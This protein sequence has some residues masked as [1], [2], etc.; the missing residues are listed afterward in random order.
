MSQ[1]PR[2]ATGGELTL[3]RTP[4]QWSKVFAAILVPQVI[5]RAR[6][7]QTFST[8][9]RVLEVTYDTPSGTLG[10]VRADMTVLV[11]S[12]LDA[13]DKGICRLRSID[14]TKFYI[15]KTSDIAWA[16][17]LFLTVINDFG[18]WAREITM[19][20]VTAFMDSGIAYTNQH[21]NFDPVVIMGDHRVLKKTGASIST[22]FDWTGS[23]MPDGSAVSSYSTSAPTSSSSSGMTTSAPT[24]HFNAVGWHPIYLTVTGANGKSFFGMRWVY[25]YDKNNLP[26][27]AQIGDNGVDVDSGGWQ[28]S[29]TLS[30]NVDL[31]LVR[32]RALVLVFAEDHYGNTVQSIGPITNCENR[33]LTGW[34][35]AESINWNPEQGQVEFTCYGA[36]HWMKII[37][38]YPS[39][40]EHTTKT[41][42]AWTEI[43]NLNVRLGLFHFLH[44]RT[45]ATRVMDVYLPDD[46]RI[47]AECSSL[48]G[49]LW[50][51]ITE[52]AWDKTF[53][54]AGVDRFNRLWIK[55][56]PQLTPTASRTW[57]TVMDITEDD[58]AGDVSFERAIVNE[59]SVVDMSGGSINSAGKITPYFALSPGRAFPHY[60]SPDIVTGHLFS[61][62]AECLTICGLYWTWRNNQFKDIPIQFSSNMRLIDC[63]PN[64]KCTITIASGDTPRGIAYSGG[65]IPTSVKFVHNADTG[66]LYTEAHFEAE[67]FEGLAVVGDFIGSDDVS[68]PPLAPLPPLPPLDYPIIPGVIEPSEE[69]GPP[70]VLLHGTPGLIYTENFNDDASDIGWLVMNPGLTQAQYQQISWIGLDASGGIYVARR[71]SSVNAFIAY[72][73]QIGATFTIIEDMASIDAKY[74]GAVFRGV[75]AIGVDPLTG[76]LAYVLTG[77]LPLGVMQSHIY[78]GSGTSFTQG[79]DLSGRVHVTSGGSLSFGGGAWRLTTNANTVAPRFIAISADG[80]T[81]LSQTILPGQVQIEAAEQ[82]APVSTTDTILMRIQHSLIRVTQNGAVAGDFTNY[83]S[84]GEMPN[85]APWDNKTAC[86]PSGTLIMACWNTSGRKGKSADGGSSFT[87]MP[88]LPPGADYAYA[89]A[90]GAGVASRWI[91]GLGTTLRYSDDFGGAWGDKSANLLNTVSFTPGIDIIKVVEY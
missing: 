74:P 80:S 12:T 8:T 78:V 34:I 15:G 76:T 62:Q 10:N 63:F 56:H 58:W 22:V 3:F 64:Q 28:F 49:N 27:D 46:T 51:Q 23:Y 82:H 79:V 35:G 67:T 55:L 5:Y 69:G 91:A 60:G 73:P 37:P 20:G 86:D 25:V 31:S 14:G 44:W 85:A 54:R 75:N 84:S 13:H 90:G 59:V 41:A 7:N 1:I 40:V 29:L 21:T 19:D 81:I 72:A 30:D 33:V 42:A 39:G 47:M 68:I 88:V 4:G 50:S 89:Y 32:D 18:L 83:L 65:L 53:A 52:I 70:K 61:S 48:A 45:T 9:D 36:H 11:G 17:N 2:A 38:A 87:G 24:I 57:A 26:A 71:G 16:D 77:N 66:Y 43:K 6:V